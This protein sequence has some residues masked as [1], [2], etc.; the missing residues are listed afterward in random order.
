MT[1]KQTNDFKLD[2]VEA[3]I[4]EKDHTIH[5]GNSTRELGQRLL[6]EYPHGRRTFQYNADVDIPQNPIFQRRSHF[7]ID[8]SVLREELF[9]YS[10]FLKKNTM[11]II[12]DILEEGWDYVP[13]EE[14]NKMEGRIDKIEIDKINKMDIEEWSKNLEEKFILATSKALIVDSA[15]ICRMEDEEEKKQ[16]ENFFVFTSNDVHRPFINALRQITEIYFYFKSPEAYYEKTGEKFAEVPIGF[17]TQNTSDEER[18]H[19]FRLVQ[20]NKEE[21]IKQGINSWQQ[22]ENDRL[23]LSTIP[24]QIEVVK[25]DC[26]VITPEK[27]VGYVFGWPKYLD[28][29]QTALDKLHLRM[30]EAIIMGK[31]GINRTVVFNTNRSSDVKAKLVRQTARGFKSLGTVYEIQGG[32]NQP[33]DQYYKVD[34]T[35]I[36]DLKSDI[37]NKHLNEDA[38]A[39]KQDIEG[40][41]ET[42][43]LGGQ[44][45]QTMEHKSAKNKKRFY[46]YLEDVIKSINDVFFGVDPESYRV[47]FRSSAEE[48]AIEGQE[49]GEDIPNNMEVD[50]PEQVAHSIEVSDEII[51]HAMGIFQNSLDLSNFTIYEG[52]MF[53][54]GE[55]SYPESKYK[56]KTEYYSPEDIKKITERPV[57]MGYVDPSPHILSENSVG[58]SGGAGYYEI[59]GFDNISHKDIT[60]FYIH[61]DY[62]K[63]YGKTIKVSPKFAR[64]I[65]DHGKEIF[66]KNVALIP[67]GFQS[68][69][70]YSGL[71]TEA[72]KKEKK[73][74]LV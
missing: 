22:K 56:D 26:V 2:V 9:E 18:I 20:S 68:R 11:E 24:S 40:S 37:Y 64:K 72:H 70:E 47:K 1:L 5:K 71:S 62:A 38:E 14:V 61:N 33:L 67:P 36:P 41:P 35:I 34:G 48:E 21:Q 45:P 43:A 55:Y 3:A 8:D 39:V 44:A 4:E 60:R 74:N 29:C 59:L 52:N 73:Q 17:L 66:I 69:A 27:K 65:T 50:F 6:K 31:G 53:Q 15:F 16:K 23:K 13:I 49:E 63:Q 7:T 19:R 54:A 42:G 46:R 57:K 32:A 30:C 10:R 12:Q 28:L 51:N 58:V 25:R